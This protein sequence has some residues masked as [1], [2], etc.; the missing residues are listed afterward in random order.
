MRMS[1]VV[2]LFFTAISVWAGKGDIITEFTLSGQPASGVRGLAYDSTDR[3][4]WA[5]GPQNTN[6][7]IFCKFKNDS[8][9]TI[10]QNWMKIQ[11]QDWVFDIGYPYIYS[12]VKCIVAADQ[13]SPTLKLIDPSNGNNLGSIAG[14]SSCS[15][16]ACNP[17]G[18]SIYATDGSSSYIMWSGSNWQKWAD[19]HTPPMGLGY[20]W[21]RVFVVIGSPTYEIQVFGDKGSYGSLE[22]TIKLNTS[23]YMV[24]LSAGRVNVVNYNE[25]LYIAFF[26]PSIV[27]KEVE[28]GD[29]KGTSIENTSVG[30]IKMMF[31]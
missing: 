25:S 16:L 5:A 9:H 20:A 15:G 30:Y 24:G 7:I 4:I 17:S 12:S 28:V 31:H 26:Y 22:D 8:S 14:P 1:F 3:N 2:L 21:D 18:A 29:Y 6:N 10:I 23:G 19:C 13:T 11:N 27:I